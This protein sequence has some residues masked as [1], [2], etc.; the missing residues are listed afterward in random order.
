MN[1]DFRAFEIRQFIYLSGSLTKSSAPLRRWNAEETDDLHPKIPSFP[2]E[3]QTTLARIAS[4]NIDTDD[5]PY[6]LNSFASASNKSPLFERGRFY[7]MYSAKRNER[8]KRKLG[9]ETDDISFKKYSNE[10]ELV[11]TIGAKRQSK[12][13]E[14]GRKSIAVDFLVD[15]NQIRGSRYS[16]RSSTKENKKPPLSMSFDKSCGVDASGMKCV[17]TRRVSRKI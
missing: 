17:T 10:Y 16:L 3:L 2:F 4:G 6:R 13:L 11:P 15:R 12:R 9:I 5:L 7:E 8:L 14:S 1:L